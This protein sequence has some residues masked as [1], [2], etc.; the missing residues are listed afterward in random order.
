MTFTIEPGLYDREIGLGVRVEDVV[1]VTEDGCEVITSDVPKARD[2]VAAL[3]GKTGVLD[4]L[5]G[6]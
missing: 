5:D 4:W 3:V 2:E 6:R 1:V